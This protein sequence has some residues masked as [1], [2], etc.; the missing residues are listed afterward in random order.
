MRW[1]YQASI[2]RDPEF[3]WLGKVTDVAP[4]TFKVLNWGKEFEHFYDVVT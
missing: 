4:T 2:R 3:A 1:S